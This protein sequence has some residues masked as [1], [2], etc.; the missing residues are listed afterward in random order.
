LTEVRLDN[1]TIDL[2]T[3]RNTYTLISTTQNKP[4][5]G[6]ARTLH[7]AAQ[8]TIQGWPLYYMTST[9][10][11]KR[12]LSPFCFFPE[13]T[14]RAIPLFLFYDKALLQNISVLLGF[15]GF[16][17]YGVVVCGQLCT[18]TKKAHRRFFLFPSLFCW[19]DPDFD[20]LGQIG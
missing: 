2:S 6:T 5:H 9:T 10:R 3:T 13:R 19:I 18:I 7:P 15:L 4:L 14:S 20:L 1:T 11:P 16:M 12:F 8:V 17:G